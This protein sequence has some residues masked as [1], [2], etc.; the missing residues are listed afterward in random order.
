LTFVL[1]IPTGFIRSGLLMLFAKGKKKKIW[2]FI[3]IADRLHSKQ[4]EWFWCK[5]TRR[6][7]FGFGV[8]VLLS[9]LHKLFWGLVSDNNVRSCS[10]FVECTYFGRKRQQQLLGLIL[11]FDGLTLSSGI[12]CSARV[13][14]LST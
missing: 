7:G 4:S 6:L 8:W 9:K 11:P 13:P 12:S 10:F 5:G 2:L 14:I 1:G 3:H